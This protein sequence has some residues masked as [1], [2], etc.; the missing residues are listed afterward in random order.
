M[1]LLWGLLW[2]LGDC[3][4]SKPLIVDTGNSRKRLEET[5]VWLSLLALFVGAMEEGT[6]F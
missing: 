2:A 6:K 5:R 4:L 1:H 3:R